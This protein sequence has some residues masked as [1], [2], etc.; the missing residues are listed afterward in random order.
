MQAPDGSIHASY[1]VFL[2]H[3]PEGEPRKTIRHARFNP[4]WI[5]AGG[6]Q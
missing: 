1:S 4:E 6:A 5:E 2:N 3:L